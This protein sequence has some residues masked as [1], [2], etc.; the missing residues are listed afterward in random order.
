MCH[1]NLCQ[2][3]AVCQRFQTGGYKCICHA[4]F[5]GEKTLMILLKISI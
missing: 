5:I 4:G 2:N 3:N 1:F